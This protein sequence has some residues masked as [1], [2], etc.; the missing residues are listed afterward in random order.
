MLTAAC[1][2]PVSPDLAVVCVS[3]SMCLCRQAALRSGSDSFLLGPSGYGFLHPT[4]IAPHD[5]LRQI[6][7]NMT[8]AAAAQ[9]NMTSYVH[10]DE[11][12][13][14]NAHQMTST[15]HKNLHAD[16]TLLLQSEPSN[17]GTAAMEEY[18]ANFQKT[19]IQAVFSPITPYVHRWVGRIAT[20]RELIRWTGSATDSPSAVADMLL[21]LPRGTMGYVYKLPDITM[22]D[23][24]ALGLALQDTHVKLVGHRE[25][26]VLAAQTKLMTAV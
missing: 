23:V 24:E 2:Q 18:I 14:A 12:D 20:F 9:L 16:E 19:S 22:Q 17:M 25:L 4:A 7:I 26:A 11:Y 21:Q 5:S 10:W 8:A 1:Y 15:Q 3:I 6:M 13:N